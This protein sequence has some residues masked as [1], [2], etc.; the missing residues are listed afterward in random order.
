VTAR[1]LFVDDEPLMREFYTMI[2]AILG[3]EFEVFTAPS[4]KE[5]LEFLEHTP[6]DIVV[7]DLVM[8]EMTG[9]EFMTEVA[10]EHPESM[11]IVLS[12]YEDQLTVAQCLMFGHRYL[13]KPF[14]LKNLAAI[15]KRICHLKHQVG[16]EKIRRVISGLGALPT[17]PQIYVRLVEALNSEYTGISDVAEIVTQDPGLTVKLLQIANSAYFG[18]SRRVVLPIEAVQ[19]VG[20]EILRGLV[21]CVQAFKFYQDK[22]I[23]SISATQL[24]QHS[25]ETAQAARRLAAFENL[26]SSVCDETFVS[27]LLHDIG[28][29]VMAANAESDY[30]IVVR[31]SRLEDVPMHQI[32]MEVFGATHAQVGAYLLGLWGLPDP[33]VNTVELHHELGSVE[34]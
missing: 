10:R 29:L 12:A 4:G 5:G 28:K 9:H 33:V 22:A 24:W 6:V 2:G 32:E 18:M 25:L 7:S 3:D 30:Q 15:L 8:P 1:I 26:P 17:P 34:Q 23:R 31:R 20:L 19:V 14:D 21:V 13:S 27:G 11:R 16:G